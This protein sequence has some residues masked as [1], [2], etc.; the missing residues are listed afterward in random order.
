MAGGLLGLPSG[1]TAGEDLQ[2]AG[3]G[4]MT[5][6][7]LAGSPLLFL[8][9]AVVEA[10]S[11][12]PILIQAFSGVPRTQ[13]TIL[14][15]QRLQQ[16]INP[17]VQ[18][19]GLWWYK[20]GNLGFADSSAPDITSY[21]QPAFNYTT[22]TLNIPFNSQ[23][24]HAL[25]GVIGEGQSPAIFDT[26][27]KETK[28]P[29]PM[30][31]T[32]AA[33]SILFPGQRFPAELD[34]LWRSTIPDFVNPPPP[35]VGPQNGG[36]TGP[37]P[38]T[39]DQS[40]SQQCC[41]AIVAALS[42]LA[43]QVYNLRLQPGFTDIEVLTTVIE[44]IASYIATISQAINSLMS[45][46]GQGIGGLGQALQSVAG[47]LETTVTNAAGQEVNALTGLSQA[48]VTALGK[49]DVDTENSFAGVTH[50]IMNM[51]PVD[52]SKIEEELKCLCLDAQPVRAF[53]QGLADKGVIDSDIASLALSA[54][55]QSVQ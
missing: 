29:T 25:A 45:V 19:L 18:M 51:K 38:Q 50:A 7:E 13:K 22:A 20:A 53:I 44:R 43:T 14:T 36:P 4:L 11:I 35:V 31:I 34:L 39:G 37:G 17:A 46:T 16:S 10:A 30:Y 33:F 9:G 48:I 12:I 2:K 21:F 42:N 55:P 49:I 3:Q 15:G 26:A 5:T 1:G 32:Q 23:A 27:Y 41:D 28:F 6:G 54:V 52:L 40:F 24:W 47:A 8:A